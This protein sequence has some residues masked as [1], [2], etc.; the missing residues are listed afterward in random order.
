MSPSSFISA[1]L[2]LIT[3]LHGVTR[4]AQKP[5]PPTVDALE[6]VL[7]EQYV[8]LCDRRAAIPAELTE[9]MRDISRRHT[10]GSKAAR[11]YEMETELFRHLLKTNALL[12]A[13]PDRTDH[14]LILLAYLNKS[15]APA[16]PKQ[17]L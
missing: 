14:N 12:L 16:D 1:L 8:L 13:I 6:T 5:P 10:T 9:A 17:E 15:C 3:L 7:M 4:G 2:T 11:R